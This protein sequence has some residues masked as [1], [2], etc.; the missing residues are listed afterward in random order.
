MSHKQLTQ[1]KLVGLREA[2]I[3]VKSL[4]DANSSRG[5]LQDIY[6][7]QTSR[8]LNRKACALLHAYLA[9]K[10]GDQYVGGMRLTL[11][12]KNHRNNR[13]I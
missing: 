3:K 8:A 4:F 12:Y 10:K 13:K 9:D 6:D 11:V 1:E 2:R 5:R 7:E